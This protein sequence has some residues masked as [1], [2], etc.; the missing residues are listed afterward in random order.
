MQA[1]A[2]ELAELKR[3]VLALYGQPHPHTPRETRT[4]QPDVTSPSSHKG[5]H[6]FPRGTTADP[7]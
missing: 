2:K 3:E 1:Q 6:D 7:P 4:E 5:D